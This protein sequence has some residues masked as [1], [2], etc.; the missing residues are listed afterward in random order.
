MNFNSRKK[1]FEFVSNKK[2]I[3]WGARMTGIGAL[4]QLK[5]QN[6]EILNFV[7]SDEALVG[8]F[9]HG[10]KVHHP[11]E[12]KEIL[13]P[14]DNVVILIAVSLKE[15]EI[16]SQLQ[17]I[18]IA[19]VPVISFLDEMA[20]YYTVDILGSCNLKCASC[21]HSIE[22]T[23]V[24]KGSMS[25]DVFK[26]VFDKIIKETPS[27][28]HISLYSW[29]EPLLHPHIDKIIDYVHE[30]NV[31]VAL[32]S[33]LSIKFEK[34]IEK[35][36]K[37]APDYL[38][39][40]LSGFYPEAYDNTHQGGDIN[41]VKNNLYLIK[42]LLDK[43][44]VQTLIDIN[45]HL[46]RD[47]S[48]EN[49]EQMEKLADELGFAL[50]KTYAL[51]MPLE[52][53]ISHVN[54]KPDLQTEQLQNNLL[55]TIDEGIKASSEV[56]LPKNTCPFREN[57]ININ[58]DL[59]VPVCCTVWKRDDN[60]VASNFLESNVSEIN[61]NKKNV[62]LCNKC[63]NLRLPEYNMGFNKRGWEKYAKE[64]SITD[65]GSK[66]KIFKATNKELNENRY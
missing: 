45:Y 1:I 33:N 17:K 62:D 28:S 16:L 52:R 3:I 11:G 54:G 18:D 25:F 61:K 4:R 19:N 49:I 60:V 6:I 58:A 8:K 48:G 64:K 37:S 66:K 56:P 10:F 46:Y 55:V 20:P 44:K 14:H 39:V 5:E 22:D 59:S 13:K 34:R 38:K 32:S 51:V 12:L 53:V 21:P 57:Q 31:A 29:G 2:V 36:I 26:S 23:D 43:Y 35:I 63:M 65:I 7:D 27:I 9:V 42:K 15:D 47:N 24:P 40:S 41:L 50:S 30:K